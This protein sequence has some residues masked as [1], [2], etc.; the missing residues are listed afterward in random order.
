ML[1]WFRK[2]QAATGRRS[3]VWQ[4]AHLS[5]QGDKHVRD[6]SPCQD[7]S[8]S[9]AF[10]DGTWAY[11]VVADGHGSERHF[12]SGSGSKLAVA[13]MHD[14]FQSF[15]GKTGELGEPSP[16]ELEELWE[17]R[18][19]E[20]VRRWRAK[21]HSDLVKN[22]AL[23]PGRTDGERGLVRYLDDFARRNG[24]AQL[25]L[26][27]WQLRRF[28][29]YAK[30]VISQEAEA[31]GPLPYFTDP[32]W[33]QAKYGGWQ[34][35]AYGT[36]L[37]GVLVGPETLHWV[38]IG[39]GAMVQ[40]VGGVAS[41]LIP[42]PAEAVGNLTPS[43]CDEDAEKKIRYGTMPIRSGQM[44]SG[45]VLATDG[46]PNSY[47]D[48]T[49]FF[50]FC[51]DIAQRADT[52][53]AFSEDLP[54]WL[55]TISRNGSGDD[56]SVALAWLRELPTPGKP[57]PPP[58]EARDDTARE[59]DVPAETSE[60]VRA[61]SERVE[62][63]T[64]TPF[65]ERADSAMELVASGSR[66]QCVPTRARHAASLHEDDAGTEEPP[67]AL[68]TGIPRDVRRGPEEEGGDRGAEDGRSAQL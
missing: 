51:Q 54:K 61:E 8:D 16:A 15:L 63:E 20:I 25:E 47:D 40:I 2:S 23:V 36:T 24:Y 28:E 43:L 34:A 22:P 65:D 13:T 5:L 50:K 66:P 6:G 7:D 59:Q 18:A 46:V 17:E 39:D 14:V 42:P 45:I 11:V 19:R 67:N 1:A 26:L 56:V 10:E 49:G 21:V 57:A 62:A 48:N 12:R 4:T 60:P 32:R 38:Q 29:Q 9:R 64:R 31:L 68:E 52:S 44:P 53:S 41:Y 33:D 37:L 58:E 3:L 27:F 35:K 30:E 55:K